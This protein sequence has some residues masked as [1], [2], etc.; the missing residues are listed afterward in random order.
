MAVSKVR[1]ASCRA[2]V[3]RDEVYYSSRMVNVCTETCFRA[4]Y[5][6]QRTKQPPEK[7][8]R[9]ARKQTRLDADVRQRIRRRDANVCRWCGRAGEQIHHVVYR[10]QGGADHVSNLVLLCAEHHAMVHSNKRHYQPVL[11]A[12]LWVGYVEG[13]W[14]TGPE[15]E[16]RLISDG[17]IEML[18]E[19][20]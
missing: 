17:V 10:S 20:A 12:L 14:L 9:I 4:V 8:T 3:P 15:I 1:C 13:R 2:Y 11:L 19:S 6:K 18:G 5:E 16:R 7:V